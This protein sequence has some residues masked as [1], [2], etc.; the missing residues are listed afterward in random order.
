MSWGQVPGGKSGTLKCADCGKGMKLRRV[1]KKRKGSSGTFYGCS[2]YPDCEATLPA[3]EDGT[4]DGEPVDEDTRTARR[5]ALEAFNALWR[6][7]KGG[8]KDSA[9]RLIAGGLEIPIHELEISKLDVTACLKVLEIVDHMFTGEGEDPFGVE[10]P[11]AQDVECESP[12]QRSRMIE[13]CRPNKK[14]HENAKR[15]GIDLDL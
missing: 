8:S 12:D 13:L 9:R 11:Y 10:D 6:G 14:A 4:P 15:A 5:D 3:H 7:V 2:G 1:K